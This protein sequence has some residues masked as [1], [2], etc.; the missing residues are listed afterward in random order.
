MN[1]LFLLFLVGDQWFASDDREGFPYYAYQRACDVFAARHLHQRVV[2]VH[3]P[4]RTLHQFLGAYPVIY[5]G[6][7]SVFYQYGFSNQVLVFSYD[8]LFLVDLESLMDFMLVTD[9]VLPAFTC[10]M[11]LGTIPFRY[12]AFGMVFKCS[13]QEYLD[14]LFHGNCM[15]VSL[16]HKQGEFDTDNLPIVPHRPDPLAESMNMP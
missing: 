5:I 9:A 2:S 7:Q 14:H 12:S 4:V 16:S 13:N 10:K 3:D 1:I 11:C 15:L 6:A 8:T